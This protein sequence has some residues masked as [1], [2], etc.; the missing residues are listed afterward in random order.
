M[1]GTDSE[2][3]DST[4]DN[5]DPTARFGS[6]TFL[7]LNGFTGTYIDPGQATCDSLSGNFNGTTFRDFRPGRGFYCGSREEVGNTSFLNDEE[8]T[9]AY[10]NANWAVT[11]NSELYANLLYN[12]HTTT[13]SS[14]SRFWSPD[15]NGSGGYI[16][17]RDPNSA[18]PCNLPRSSAR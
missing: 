14:F 8:S 12:W 15:I 4:E 10:L 1:F 17:E 18:T 11:D 9:S 2:W 5:P 7:I 3:F 16:W 6:R 13:S